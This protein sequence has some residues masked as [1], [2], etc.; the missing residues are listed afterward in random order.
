MIINFSEKCGSLDWWR[1]FDRT[2]RASF[3]GIIIG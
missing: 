3:R 2:K 1:Q